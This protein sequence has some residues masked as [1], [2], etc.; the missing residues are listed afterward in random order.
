MSRR[1]GW[2]F[3]TF[4]ETEA[5]SFETPAKVS[6]DLGGCWRQDP[7]PGSCWISAI[8]GVA[9]QC[10]KTFDI[11]STRVRTW[12]IALSAQPRNF[13]YLDIPTLQD[14]NTPLADFRPNSPLI[15]HY[16]PKA[17][18]HAGFS[19]IFYGPRS[20]DLFLVQ[21]DV[22]DKSSHEVG[23]AAAWSDRIC[24]PPDTHQ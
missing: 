18:I 5:P 3:L 14:H 4:R 20:N 11:A 10:V 16:G 8:L 2:T 19:W 21:I 23:Q 17:D 9:D 1:F 13:V 24:A 22:F 6:A 15:G 7:A 12:R